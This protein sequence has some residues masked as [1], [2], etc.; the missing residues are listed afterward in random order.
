M[1]NFNPGKYLDLV[2]KYKVQATALLIGIFLVLV[3]IAGRA[4]VDCPSKEVVCKGELLTIE[5]L[6]EEIKK[7]Q[8]DS[9]DKLRDQRDAD[10]EDCTKRIRS[11]I[12]KHRTT[13]NIVTC[14]EVKALMPQCKKRGALE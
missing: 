6:F 12:D 2:E 13:A 1:S 4:T 11:A 3:F 5:S 10:D 8:N 14:E 9:T 7:C